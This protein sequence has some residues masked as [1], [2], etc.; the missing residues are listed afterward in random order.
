VI[1]IGDI[2]THEGEPANPYKGYQ[3]GKVRSEALGRFLRGKPTDG[4][5]FWH[6]PSCGGAKR[7]TEPPPV[8][9]EVVDFY[10]P[11]R[12]PHAQ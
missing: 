3:T 5:T 10:W 11:E 1:D 12:S 8:M 4:L 7:L 9:P 2:L 6:A